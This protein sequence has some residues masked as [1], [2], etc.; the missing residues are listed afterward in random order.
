MLTMLILPFLSLLLKKKKR[1][2]QQHPLHC[3][4]LQQWILGDLHKSCLSKT[5]SHQSDL[6]G[7]LHWT[8]ALIDYV[9][10]SNYS[11]VEL[12]AGIG[13]AGDTQLAFS[14]MK[15]KLVL[16]ESAFLFSATQFIVMD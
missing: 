2:K 7:L 13:T 4:G 9:I 16:Y 1:E 12:K 8:C 3:F 14:Q 15:V 6:D 10:K 5:H 11:H